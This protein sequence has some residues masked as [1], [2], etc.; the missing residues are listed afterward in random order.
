MVLISEALVILKQ[1]A[2]K[3]ISENKAYTNCKQ[4]RTSARHTQPMSHRSSMTKPLCLACSLCYV[5]LAAQQKVT[6]HSLLRLRIQNW[7]NSSPKLDKT[8]LPASSLLD[9]L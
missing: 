5:Q 2:A 1:A 3:P 6:I 9:E 4:S 7:E 8:V